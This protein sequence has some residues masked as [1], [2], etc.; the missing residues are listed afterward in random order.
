MVNSIERKLQKNLLNLPLFY[1][2]DNVK[3]HLT[4]KM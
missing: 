3:M 1:L 4:I 2:D